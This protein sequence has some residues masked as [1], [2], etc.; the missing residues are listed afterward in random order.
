MGALSGRHK[1]DRGE[2]QHLQTQ[3]LGS[4]EGAKPIQNTVAVGKS[5]KPSTNNNVT[6]QQKKI[7][8]I[9]SGS[10]SYNGSGTCS[11]VA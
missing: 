1:L 5:F 3:L 2:R 10:G 4:L 11:G 6:F 9:S 8:G 7:S